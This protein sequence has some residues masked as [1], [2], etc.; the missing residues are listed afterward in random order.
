LA[1]TPA[2]QKLRD[3]EEMFAV[4]GTYDPTPIIERI[5]HRAA[6]QDIPAWEKAKDMVIQNIPLYNIV[7]LYPLRRA[8]HFDKRS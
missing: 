4:D 8:D 6:Y 1:N 7:Y 5:A 2:V 3:A